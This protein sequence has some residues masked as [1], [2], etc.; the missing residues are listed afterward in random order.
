MERWQNKV[1]VVTGASAGIGEAISKDLLKAGLIV[2]GL[3]R[4]KEKLEKI[5][6]SLPENLKLKFHMH[7]CD[8]G[9][10]EDVLSVFKWID[11]ELGGTDILIN[12]AGC[13]KPCD[14][15]ALDNTEKVQETVN[16]NIMGVVYCTRSAYN[17]IRERKSNGHIILINSV[18][19]HIVPNIGTDL[20]SFNIYSP[21]KHAVTAM[22]EIYRQ[23]F[24]RYGLNCKVTSISPGAVDTDIFPEECADMIKSTMPL[25]KSEDVSNA[26]LYVLGTPPH[27]Q[28]HELI[29]KPMGEM[30]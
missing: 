28:I 15:V 20:P 17:S 25:L 2:V 23:E 8:V 1:A 13:L 5:R 21:T 29:I 27:V 24:K 11:N 30:C 4:R 22:N 6:E 16:T 9:K 14:L 7:K 18:A 19:G 26:V 12:N 3:A 10:E